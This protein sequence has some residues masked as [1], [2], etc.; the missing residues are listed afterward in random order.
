MRI[1]NKRFT[2]KWITDLSKCEVFVFGSNLEGQHH[3]GAARM[4]YDRFGAEWGV[5][6]GP[7]GKCYAIPTMHGGVAD[8]QPYVEQFFDYV[9]KHP[10]LRFLVTRIGCG[11]AGFM[12]SEIAPLFNH[13]L[14]LPNVAYPKEWLP[15]MVNAKMFDDHKQTKAKTPNAVNE[16]VLIALCK[17]YS[18]QI[19]AHI[20]QGLPNLTIRYVKGDNEFGY[21]KLVDAFMSGERFNE[22]LYVW[23]KDERWKDEHRQEMVEKFFA[24]ECL[25][26]GY[27]HKVIFAGVKTQFHD[28]KGDTIYSGDVIRVIKE[29]GEE[30]FVDAVGAF[31]YENK[32]GQ[33]ILILDNHCLPLADCI[34]ENMTFERVGTV[35]YQL[36]KN[37]KKCLNSR[38]IKHNLDNWGYDASEEELKLIKAKYT[39]NYEKEDWKYKA[40][41]EMC[42]E[43]NW[44]K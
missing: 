18:Y 11:I 5:G 25:D 3:G 36:D 16:T 23:E 33:Y 22:E 42:E 19:G 31:T 7:T 34:E 38:V 2:P 4:A 29:D 14:D 44:R 39:P 12:D 9:E 26:R 20:D 40:L 37:E 13:A 10:T 35:M 6:N 43:Y 32:E 15:Y 30:Y 17:R 27:F 41:S 24:D 28:I 8:I 1:R 21:I